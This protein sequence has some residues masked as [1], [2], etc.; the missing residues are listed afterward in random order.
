MSALNSNNGPDR[1]LSCLVMAI[2]CLTCGLV[3]IFFFGAFLTFG[4]SKSGEPIDVFFAFWPVLLAGL[5]AAGSVVAAA[6]NRTSLGLWL[7]VI[8]PMMLIFL[9]A[10]GWQ[11]MKGS[12]WVG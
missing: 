1:S 5:A 11:L 3:A 7:A 12:G 9:V 10:E 4:M 8:G 6:S 2:S